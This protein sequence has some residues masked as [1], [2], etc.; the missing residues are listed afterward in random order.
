MMVRFCSP[1]FWLAVVCVVAIAEATSPFAIP[2]SP[3][4]YGPDGPWH[5]VRV[6]LGEN[7]QRVDLYPGG[8][9]ASTI[10][11]DTVCLTYPG[12]CYAERAGVFK[13]S[14]SNSTIYVSKRT[15]SSDPSDPGVDNWGGLGHISSFMMAD[16]INVG[17][18]GWVPKSSINAVRSAYQTYPNGKR[19][20]VSV[21]ILSLGAIQAFHSSGSYSLNLLAGYMHLQYGESQLPSASFGMHIGSVSAEIPGSLLMG[22]YDRNRVIGEVSSQAIDSTDNQGKY[23]IQLSDVGL[24]VASGG[25]P[26]DFESKSDLL[27]KDGSSESVLTTVEID[28]TV[29]YLYLPRDTCDA[30]A[31][32]LPVTYNKG[33]GLYFWNATEES[34]RNIVS[35]PAYLSFTFWKN[36]GSNKDITI[37]VPF[38]LL[39]LTLEK[40]LVNQDTPY[41][42]CFPTNSTYKLGRAFLQAAFLGVN[43]QKSDGGGRWFLSQAPGPTFA[44]RS[45][46]TINVNDTSIEG[47]SSSWEK[48]WDGAWE[49]LESDSGLSTGAKAGVGVGCAVAGLLIIGLVWLFFFR[50]KKSPATSEETASPQADPIPELGISQPPPVYTSEIGRGKETHEAPSSPTIRHELPS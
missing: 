19:Y 45:A 11:T 17:G 36:E 12:H 14:A 44:A 37:K 30:I 7:S 1:S 26:W 29:P 21:G 40:P 6:Y 47:A 9:W 34:Y 46:A 27:K 3:L 4:S 38:K 43:W 8:R 41:F 23:N 33:L 24:G 39:N 16:R 25:S 13:T 15:N 48:S 2:W 22:G 32:E 18:Y 10:L 5:A 20:P 49:P 31:K 42:P 35:S 28:P 50:R